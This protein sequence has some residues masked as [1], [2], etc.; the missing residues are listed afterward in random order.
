MDTGVLFV[1]AHR[2]PFAMMVLKGVLVLVAR[3]FDVV[4]L[5]SG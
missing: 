4:A 3:S 2:T 1:I 5:R